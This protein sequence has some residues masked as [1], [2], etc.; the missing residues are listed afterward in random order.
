M[1]EI[2]NILVPFNFSMISNKALEYA[3]GFV[4]KDENMKI[5]LA[6][7]TNGKNKEELEKSF[8]KVEEEYQ[9]KLKHK[10][11]WVLANGDLTES[12]THIHKEEKIDL[13]IMGTHGAVN[14]DEITNTSKLVLESNFPILVIPNHNKEFQLKN[15][16]LVLGTEEIENSKI[17][18]TLLDVTRRFHAK[19]HIV[20]I[21]NKPGKYGYSKVDEKNENVVEYYLEN[22]YSEHTFIENPDVVEGILNYVDDKEIDMITILPRNHVKKSTP[23]DGKL[24]QMLTLHSK[25]PILA[26]D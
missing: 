5:T 10:I 2:S 17:L 4:G 26:I 3:V 18:E 8:K 20:T 7:I 22:F 24:T 12:L 9:P 23:S 13:V 1:N 14:E 21:V 15:I 25:V 6:Y 11:E 16:A 19:V